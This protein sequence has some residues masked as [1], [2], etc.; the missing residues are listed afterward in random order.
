MIFILKLADFEES[1][2]PSIMWV[3]F[4]QSVEGFN[5]KL[6][7]PRKKGISANKWPLE[8][9]VSLPWVSSWQPCPADTR[10][11]SPLQLYCIGIDRLTEGRQTAIYPHP[12]LH[13]V[14]LRN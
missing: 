3:G 2:L 7:S 1:Q 9:M 12:H 11:S 6:T 14:S 10:L 8:L 13:S 5:R 4:I